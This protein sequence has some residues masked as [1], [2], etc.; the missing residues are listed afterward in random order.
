MRYALR[1]VFAV[2]FLLAAVPFAQAGIYIEQNMH[3]D[4]FTIMGKTQPAKDAVQKIWM[5]TDRMASENSES[6]MSVIIRMDEKKLYFINNA[7]QSYSVSPLPFKFP[8]EMEKMMA[9]FQFQTNVQK[10]GEKKQIGPYNCEGVLLTLSGFMNMNIKMWITS[11]IKMP[12]E[13]YYAMSTEMV[14]YSP[15]MREMMEKMRSLGSGF[16]VE[17]EMTGDVMGTKTHSVTKLVKFEPN[18]TI[19]ADKFAPPAG[20]K[21]VPMDFQ[22]LMSQQ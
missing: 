12:Y 9:A 5:E 11:D 2:V 13:K 3:T 6:T 4:A 14:A 22:K 18:A 21:E 1:V 15:A 16:A 7:K 20:Y 19:P 17:Q 8:P 10:T